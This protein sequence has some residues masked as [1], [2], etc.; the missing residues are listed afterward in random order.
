MKKVYTFFT[1]FLMGCVME[2]INDVLERQCTRIEFKD[3]KVKYFSI[4]TQ[5]SEADTI[6]EAIKD[7]VESDK[8]LN[9]KS[10]LRYFIEDVLYN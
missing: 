10:V 7:I 3:G 2:N 6:E 9:G 8:L 5:W 4:S 1:M